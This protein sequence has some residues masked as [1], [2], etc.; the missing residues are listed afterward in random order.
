MHST[1]SN[2]WPAKS[3]SAN[4]G[5]QVY[6]SS[7]PEKQEGKKQ[8]SSH[9][10]KQSFSDVV[11]FSR[12]NTQA[13]LQLKEKPRDCFP[14]RPTGKETC[15]DPLK[16][17]KVKTKEHGVGH[18]RCGTQEVSSPTR[19]SHYIMRAIQFGENSL[20]YCSEKKNS[21]YFPISGEVAARKSS[22]TT[23]PSSCPTRPRANPGQAGR[24]G[25]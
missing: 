13:I 9:D 18:P 19:H 22:A 14:L 8:L 12:L 4:K 24:P 1:G 10:K 15:N 5:F 21:F 6:V 16:L 20:M 7:I 23:R 11:H 2:T 25:W 17:R 3:S